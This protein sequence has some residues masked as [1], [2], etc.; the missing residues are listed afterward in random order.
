MKFNPL[1][2]NILFLFSVS[3]I[4]YAE[5]FEIDFVN[6][7][8]YSQFS[9]FA[10]DDVRVYSTLQNS[11]GFDIEG[12]IQF[13][14]NDKFIGDFKFLIANG[15]TTESW[16]DWR[17]SEGEHSLS[18][19]ITSLKK[20]GIA[21][22]PTDI[23]LEKEI[24]V[25]KQINIDID[26]DKDG[27]GNKDD[28]D[29]D[30]DSYS[31]K[32]EIELGTN[33]LVFDKVVNEVKA[34]VPEEKTNIETEKVIGDNLMGDIKNITT[35]TLERSKELTTTTKDILEQ[36]KEVIDEEIEKDKKI[37]L[38]Q[39]ELEESVYEDKEGVNLYTASIIDAVPS[40][41]EVYSFILAALIYILN[42]WWILLAI[43]FITLW[44]VGKMI[45]NKLILRRF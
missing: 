35:K 26:T 43:I 10:G 8:R 41:K 40:L 37:E 20:L 39:K 34:I 28:L 42:S 14:D 9:F 24:S 7:F 25:I 16:T 18:A 44:L 30:N 21:Q 31:D 38:A 12:I 5:N 45:K 27:I 23:S 15:K 17:P 33:P 29:D 11:A 2:L 6:D 32:K 36:H 1:I 4:V 19:K 3:G 22:K 13:Y